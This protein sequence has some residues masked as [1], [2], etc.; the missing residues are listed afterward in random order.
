MSEV[1]RL[2]VE[3]ARLAQALDAASDED[4]RVR[5]AVGG[6]VLVVSGC[7]HAGFTVNEG[8]RCPPRWA[9]T[10]WSDEPTS[11]RASSPRGRA[12]T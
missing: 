12:S 1:G 2:M 7:D 8:A 10:T 3:F 5:V 11:S 6:S 4:A 9:A